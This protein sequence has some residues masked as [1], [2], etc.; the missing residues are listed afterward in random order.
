M[1][2]GHCS[3]AAL[4]GIKHMNTKRRFMRHR[5]IPPAKV[6]LLI[7][8][9]IATDWVGLCKQMG[10]DPDRPHTGHMILADILHDLRDAGLIIFDDSAGPHRR[11]PV[12]G[13]IRVSESWEKIQ[14]SLGISLA[15]I[16]DLVPD[17]TMIV[18][19]YF[20]EPSPPPKACDI[21]VLM[22]F[23]EAL[24]PVYDDHIRRVADSLKLA[25]ARADD[26]FTAKSVVSDIWNAICSSRL[27]VADC[28][29]R[30]PNV[31]Y[32]IGLAHVV[33]KPVILTTQSEG[34][35][36]FDVGHLRYIK[37]EYT[38]RGMQ[39]FEAR[40]VETIKYELGL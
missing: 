25:V 29:S 9:G 35:V 7:R 8:D 4:A 38:P 20:G 13:Q 2:F 14:T 22:P 27:I 19:P 12:A 5:G 3:T 23:Q 24:R 33:G 11:R 32:E 17:E 21:F 36:P 26:F 1:P 28:T 30:N 40:L 39:E 34:D 15:Q 10:W 37:Y 31:F 18:R 6:L 16:T